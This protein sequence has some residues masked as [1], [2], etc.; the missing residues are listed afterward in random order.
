MSSLLSLPVHLVQSVSIAALVKYGVKSCV[1]EKLVTSLIENEQSSYAS[2]G[3]M[4]VCDYISDIN[5]R[6]VDPDSLPKLRR[7]SSRMT[8]IEGNR[9]LNIHVLDSLSELIRDNIDEELQFLS[10]MNAHHLGRLAT[11]ARIFTA[12]GYIVQGFANF[13][14]WGEK[15][16]S[17]GGGPG[18]LATNPILFAVPMPGEDPFILDMTTSVTSE[19]AIRQR[20][21]KAQHVPS[22]WLV[23]SQGAV[24]TDPALF[25][26]EPMQ[27]FL[28]PLGDTTA[29]H[30]GFGLGLISEIFAS[31]VPGTG[32]VA[33]PA[34]AGGNS[35]FF[36][37]F[38]PE[39]LG[40]ESSC[41]CEHVKKITEYL[42]FDSCGVRMPGSRIAKNSP[43]LE[44]PRKVWCQ[45]LELAEGA[46]P[47][48]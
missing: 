38:K 29:G 8:V 40:I 37:F 7:L 11:I 30:K 13:N 4:R 43:N 2:H 33:N 1:A 18:R 22:G 25:Y 36:T 16:A 17:P 12:E 5:N 31:I 10:I 9:S 20:Y 28:S 3:I 48:N 6:V 32:N 23:N 44:I 19:G 47:N 46:N 34:S 24:V 35:A 21:L 27:A 15:V 42:T 14:G 45:I 41:F 26:C 39:T